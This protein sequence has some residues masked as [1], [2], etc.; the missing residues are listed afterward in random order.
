[1]PLSFNTPFAETLQRFVEAARTAESP[2][3]ELAKLDTRMVNYEMLY[4]DRLSAP[5]AIVEEAIRL[6]FPEPHPYHFSPTAWMVLA[7]RNGADMQ[8]LRHLEDTSPACVGALLSDE[9]ST[10]YVF[11][12]YADLAPDDTGRNER[13]TFLLDDAKKGLFKRDQHA[14]LRLMAQAAAV[15][16]V[17]AVASVD[18][19]MSATAHPRARWHSPLD[20]AFNRAV[21][22]NQPVA[23]WAMEQGLANSDDLALA[24]AEGKVP[25]DCDKLPPV[26]WSDYA[27]KAI[28][29]IWRR[30]KIGPS[31]MSYIER[32]GATV[33]YVD[34]LAAIGRLGGWC[35]PREDS[36][37]NYDSTGLP[38]PSRDLGYTHLADVA[39]KAAKMPRAPG[40][41][42]LGVTLAN[43]LWEAN[44]PHEMTPPSPEARHARAAWEVGLIGRA[45][46]ALT[47]E[48]AHKLSTYLERQSAKEGRSMSASICAHMSAPILAE[49]AQMKGAEKIPGLQSDP[50]VSRIARVNQS[51]LQYRKMPPPHGL[52]GRPCYGF[53]PATFTAV[54]EALKGTRET[55]VEFAAETARNVYAYNLSCLFGTKDRVD[56]YVKKVKTDTTPAGPVAALTSADYMTAAQFGI[57]MQPG[58][59]ISAWGDAAMKHGARFARFARLAEPGQPP[60]ATIREAVDRYATKILPQASAHPGVAR[61]CVELELD[62][63]DAQTVLDAYAAVDVKKASSEMPD[64]NI[65]GERFGLPGF[66]FHRLKPGDP[67]ALVAGVLTHCCQHVNGEASSAAIHSASSASGGCFFLE[68][69]P[70]GK[71]RSQVVGAMWGWRGQAKELCFDSVEM[72]NERYNAF[73][74]GLLEAVR[75]EVATKHPEI[76]RVTLGVDGRT[77]ELPL[78]HAKPPAKPIDFGGDDYR[79]SHQQY[80]VFTRDRNAD[81]AIALAL[82][83]LVA[84]APVHET[85]VA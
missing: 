55:P 7:L 3:S 72:I 39:Q 56:R 17:Q 27:K 79:D 10:G 51:W 29:P 78:P 12:H 48:D 50:E 41:G 83:K 9:M 14:P 16:P 62:D 2:R 37:G 84:V 82:Q 20:H 70:T 11:K 61:L 53:K 34:R 19:Q 49:I 43:A 31:A 77:P 42:S 58:W 18:T 85:G 1:M 73:V 25:D 45:G 69:R 32:G 66:D 54:V 15:L 30:Q 59:D 81:R 74:P 63:A 21:E 47:D 67:R 44:H 6:R 80:A 68:K 57:P 4:N 5:K 8:S 35:G 24:F 33:A 13:L 52:S 23:A 26:Q 65:P 28:E 38:Y 60:P 46:V 40:D 64:L 36:S 71:E 75:G 76:S 22:S